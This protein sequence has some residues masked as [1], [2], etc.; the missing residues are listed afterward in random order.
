MKI[1]ALFILI[2]LSPFVIKAQ[3]GEDEMDEKPS[4]KD[5]I[6]TGGGL[7]MSFTSYSDYLAVSP[8]IGYKLSNRLAA[9]LGFQYRYTRYK[10]TNPRISTNDFGVS[11]FIRYNIYPPFF[12][13]AEYEYLNYQFVYSN[14][15]KFRKNYGSF[16]MG[17]G[18]FQPIGSRAGVFAMALY[19]FSYQNPNS[20]Y[21]YS[22][23]GS[24][25]VFR[26]GITAGF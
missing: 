5:R 7:G 15:Q 14:G 2:M 23:Y 18:L 8:L 26:A 21:D 11:P 4:A 16:M 25:W 20:P 12:L 6:F 17:G 19:N 10:T 24:P 1:G 13:H 3:W 9:G 22:P